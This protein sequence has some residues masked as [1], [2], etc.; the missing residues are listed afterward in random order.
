[1]TCSDVVN[2][3]S[4]TWS[5][6]AIYLSMWQSITG[7]KNT[8][9]ILYMDVRQLQ[10]TFLACMDY[11]LFTYFHTYGI[12]L[13]KCEN[14]EPCMYAYTLHELHQSDNDNE[15]NNSCFKMNPFRVSFN[16]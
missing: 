10:W 6:N 3:K 13:T 2:K 16:W 1:M 14:S 15:I 11:A 9:T 12:I 4:K 5:R 8:A 7:C